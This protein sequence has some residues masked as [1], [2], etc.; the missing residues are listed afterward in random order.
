M[1]QASEQQEERT[2]GIPL[3]ALH[4]KTHDLCTGKVL[5]GWGWRLAVD[6]P[7]AQERKLQK[8]NKWEPHL[9]RAYNSLVAA[10]RA[11]PMEFRSPQTPS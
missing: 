2:G 11:F 9:T 4:P 7:G 3:S 6:D 8:K 10:V 1:Q 5:G